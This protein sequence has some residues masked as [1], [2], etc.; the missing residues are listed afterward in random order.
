MTKYFILICW[1]FFITG[2]VCQP[3]LPKR[4][5][6]A[7]WVATIS[8][9]DWPSSKYLSTKDKIN[10]LKNLFDRLKDAGINAVF[11]QVR[12]ECDAFYD[13]P[14]EPWSEWLTGRRGEEPYPYFDPLKL[15]VKE[16]HSRGME[17][18]AWVNPLRVSNRTDDSSKSPNHISRVH[19]GWILRFRNYEMLDPG[20]PGVRK[21]V[22]KIV[23]DV[24][25]RYDVD[26][27]NFDDY[28]YP[29]SPRIQREDFE[30]YT[31]YGGKFSRISDW[32]RENINS[33]IK[34][35]HDSIISVNPKVKFGI[36]PFG[37][38]KNS[39][40]GT[41]GLNSYSDVYTDPL[42][43]LKDKTIDYIVPQLYW[44]IGN[45]DADYE[46]LL[47]W[48]A[49]VVDGQHLY[50]G[51][52]LT[53]SGKVLKRNLNDELNAQLNLNRDF[54]NVSGSVFFSAST[55]LKNLEVKRGN[56]IFEYRALVPDMSYKDSI[57]PLSPTGLKVYQISNSI[58]LKWKKEKPAADGETAK[59]YVIYGFEENDVNFN[60]PRNI[61]DIISGSEE[62]YEIQIKGLS[63]RDKYFAVT[64]LDALNNESSDISYVKLLSGSDTL[65]EKSNINL[66]L[67]PGCIKKKK[68]GYSPSRVINTLLAPP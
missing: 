52:T 59:F 15:A 37:I 29:Y 41:S 8:N 40:A 7:V 30:S 57:P 31:L 2:A 68:S 65:N 55:L 13:S 66:S 9:I 12:A 53:Y 64:S 1:M 34:V 26:G 39:Y 18:H 62:V 21:Y 23:A 36:S 28:F 50:I 27:V 33:L 16:A 25:R 47:K 6:R 38:V 5:M 35:V 49:S 11:F 58:I 10:E 22:A 32:R 20:I 67:K 61:I 19:P 24:V 60:D 14:Y 46:N 3:S 54:R 44:T 48:W 63:E 17:L 51:Q 45:K 42:N 43:W 4:E 56:G